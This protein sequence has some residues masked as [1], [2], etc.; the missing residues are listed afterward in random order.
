MESLS[1]D[2]LGIVFV[3]LDTRSL[4]RASLVNNLW[5]F[6]VFDNMHNF[7]INLYPFRNV[8]TD[9]IV[10]KFSDVK[11]INL[12]G[13][14]KITDSVLEYLHRIEHI[15]LTQCKDIT[16]VGL[17]RL[18]TYRDGKGPRTALLEG[19]HE[20]T[21]DGIKHVRDVDI[22]SLRYC[23]NI[24]SDCFSI[25]S[26]VR[27]LDLRNTRMT[28]F[29]GIRNLKNTQV[30]VLSN[31]FHVRDEIF[32]TLYPV[33]ADDILPLKRLYLANCR[34]TDNGLRY[35]S[36][37][38]MSTNLELLNI[39]GCGQVTDLGV[40]NL[41]DGNDDLKIYSDLCCL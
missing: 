41:K 37:N 7:Y 24:T 5:R 4:M 3:F 29:D 16:D 8:V 35:L 15:N 18:S 6:S 22:L 17:S 27:Y 30:L 36:D 26:N 21:N 19:L 1:S 31:S 11:G 10:L 34:I 32:E 25:L 12:Y 23:K 40:A 2:V 20:I 33:D 14:R 38:F 28:K 39:E 13:C 9:E